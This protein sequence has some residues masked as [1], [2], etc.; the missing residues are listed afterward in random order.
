MMPQPEQVSVTLPVSQAI[1]RM[2]RVLFQPFDLNKWFVIGFCAW[3]AGL[4]Q[5]GFNAGYHGGGPSSGSDLRRCV[6]QAR[7]FV[8]NN[9]YWIVPVAVAVTVIGLTLW[10]LVLWFSSRGRF[11]FVHCVALDKAEVAV[12]WYKFAPQANSLF[13]FRLVLGLVGLVPM[14]PLMAVIA[15][16]GW[17]MLD[18][19][20]PTAGGVLAIVGVALG[21]TLVAFIF[22]LIATLTTDFVV[23][24]MFLRADK[25]LPAWRVFL[26]LL[27]ANLGNFVL[28]FLFRIVLALAIG[29][30][31][32]V[33]VLVTC[34]IAGCLLLLPYLG[35]VLLLPV[36]VFKRS[37]SL[38]YLAQY[39]PE[40]DVFAP[41]PIPAQ[42]G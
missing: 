36:L 7:E 1:E 31:V 26:S 27:S 3:L 39:G 38:Y 15:L 13:W 9:L 34:C 21:L 22:W 14:L 8:A 33:A 42:A 11:M 17:R 12:P 24:I 4:G 37:Y 16:M 28:Y 10:L 35:T 41:P 2:K 19:G 25:C 6:E 30:V 40:F 32:V 5:H 29:M 23:P 18:G 20:E